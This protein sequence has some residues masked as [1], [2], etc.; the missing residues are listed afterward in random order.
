MASFRSRTVPLDRIVD[1]IALTATSSRPPVE[2]AV[3]GEPLPS[4]SPTESVESLR[5]AAS[6]ASLAKNVLVAAE[7]FEKEDR[8][9]QRME[10]LTQRVDEV[11]RVVH[12]ATSIYGGSAKGGRRIVD[13]E[14]EEDFL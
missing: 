7:R 4:A 11:E 6:F 5:V 14:Q 1:D 9:G 10:G 3:D 13:G 12:T 2:R 8:R